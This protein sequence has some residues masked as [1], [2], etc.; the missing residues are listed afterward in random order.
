MV[1]HYFDDQKVKIHFSWE[2]DDPHL[3]R[4]KKPLRYT[5]N[6]RKEIAL[7]AI[8]NGNQFVKGNHLNIFNLILIIN[9]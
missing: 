6:Q 1:N 8:A 3:N 7:E 2:G 5:G 9:F 4:I